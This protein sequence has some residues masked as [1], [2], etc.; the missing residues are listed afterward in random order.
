MRLQLLLPISLL[1]LSAAS[2]LAQPAK[3]FPPTG[4]R[5]GLRYPLVLA[6]LVWSVEGQVAAVHGSD[7]LV[8]LAYALRVT[9]YYGGPIKIRSIQ[10]VDPFAGYREAG[11][12]QVVAA[13]SQDITAKLNPI[14]APPVLDKGGYTDVLNPGA[15]GV[16]F[17]DVTFSS[18]DAVPAFISHRV[19]VRRENPEGQEQTF[20]VTDQPIEVER[21]QPVRLS[22][23]LLGDRWLNGDSCCKQIGGHRWAMTPINGR[24]AP[25]ET[26]AMDLVQLR[27]D[28]RVF[29]GPVDQLSSY[30][31]YGTG[32]YCAGAGVVV[33]VVRDLPDEKP[34]ASPANGSAETA[35]GNHVI[36]EMEGRRYAMY[37]HLAP[38]S[39]PVQVGDSVSTGQILGKLGNSGN[40]STP[41]LHFQ[42]MDQPSPLGARALPFVFDHMRRR[43]RYAGTLDDEGKQTFSGE[44]LSL[45]PVDGAV[46][47]RDKMPLTFDL[48]DFFEPF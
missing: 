29:S 1:I 23:P 32:V 26:F 14:P 10:I 24:A 39:I 47:L 5:D 11:T 8:H 41:H 43:F 21:R 15:S 9:N 38:H 45:A 7:G 13:D 35:A 4:N 46:D 44:P 30:Q 12:N 20:V 25:V 37:A 33:E 16:M 42:V 18:L 34:G 31:Y 48:L 3:F 17:L 40:T 2:I 6:P 22:P 19:S 36:V 28:G 27:T